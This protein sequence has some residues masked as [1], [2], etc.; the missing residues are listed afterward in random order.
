[1]K[2]F[3]LPLVQGLAGGL[4]SLEAALGM[5][6]QCFEQQFKQGLFHAL[7]AS[8]A[9]PFPSLMP[10]PMPAPGEIPGQIQESRGARRSES[11]SNC[12]GATY[13]RDRENGARRACCHEATAVRKAA[14]NWRPWAGG[15]AR[16]GPRAQGTLITGNKGALVIY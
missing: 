9:A 3:K 13:A 2:A 16:R 5:S 1:M 14:R 8:S 12:S 6:K 7:R 15:G 10:G 4:Q 11:S